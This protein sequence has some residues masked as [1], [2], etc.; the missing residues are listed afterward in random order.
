MSN[1]L[2]EITMKEIQES[3]KVILKIYGGQPDVR[4]FEVVILLS[5]HLIIHTSYFI[6]F[7]FFIVGQI[8]THVPFVWQMDP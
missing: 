3:S 4:V 7:P 1:L 2:V 8:Q 6:H 5:G